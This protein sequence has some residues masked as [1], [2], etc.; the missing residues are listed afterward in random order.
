MDR[1]DLTCEWCGKQFRRT[2]SR[3][4]I[5]K[6]C[7]TAHRQ[8]ASEARRTVDLAV[9]ALDRLDRSQTQVDAAGDAL[10]QL[11]EKP[12]NVSS[13]SSALFM[14]KA[15][16]KQLADIARVQLQFRSPPWTKT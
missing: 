7:S 12:A 9:Q 14:S 11:D 4:P 6:Y 8:R 10:E 3:G 13:S 15:F 1:N 5:P 16:D 2:H